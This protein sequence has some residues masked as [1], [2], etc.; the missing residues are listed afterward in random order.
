MQRKV[1]KRAMRLIRGGVFHGLPIFT[2]AHPVLPFL[3]I[4]LMVVEGGGSSLQVSPAI[5]AVV[6]HFI[7][8]VTS[9]CL[10]HKEGVEIPAIDVTESCDGG[11]TR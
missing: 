4:S 2:L 6:G 1:M 11:P 5:C 3:L 10:P 8:S 9:M 7:A